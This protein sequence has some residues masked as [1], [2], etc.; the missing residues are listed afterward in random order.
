[1]LCDFICMRYLEFSLIE[2][3]SGC[4]GLLVGGGDG[5]LLFNVY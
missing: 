2:T 4:Q 1:M 5:E 3:K